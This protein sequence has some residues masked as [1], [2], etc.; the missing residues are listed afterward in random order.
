MLALLA[1]A[2]RPVRAGTLAE[3]PLFETFGTADGLPSSTVYET[4]LDRRGFLWIAT[5]DGLAR[6]DGVSFRSYRPDLRDPDALPASSVQTM[7][8]DR[9]DR[10]WLGL[11]D[12]GLAVF[13]AARRKLR[14][15]A[16]DPRDPDSLPGSDVWALAQDPAGAIW[17]GTYAQ[18]LLRLWPSSGRYQR[19][20]HADGD[21][22][23]LPADDVISLRLDR[24]GWLWI[25]TPQ[26]VLAMSVGGLEEGERPVRVMSA[27]GGQFVSALGEDASGRVLIPPHLRERASLEKEVVW[28]GMGRILELWSK[29]AWDRALTMSADEEAEF[30]QAMEQLKI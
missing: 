21:A 16:H 1:C 3:T 15:Y 7:L 27:L 4:A 26:G 29:T 11:E 17:V 20:R 30:R 10:L 19:Y 23:R 8:V 9:E 25:G 28:A 18:G 22:A 12:A 13:D 5:S 14:R 2:G 24:A 6:Y